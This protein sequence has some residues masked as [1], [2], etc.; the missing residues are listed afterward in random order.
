MKASGD[1]DTSGFMGRKR[2]ASRQ[3]R[4][5]LR[6]HLLVLSFIVLIAIVVARFLLILLLYR[7]QNLKRFKKFVISSRNTKTNECKA[8]HTNI[9]KNINI[10]PISISKH[11]H[12][13]HTNMLS[14][15]KL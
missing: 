3:H 1:T 2:R 7:L 6:L 13:F 11:S 12:R 10:Y 15:P 4:N 8:E 14:S 5:Y 9:N